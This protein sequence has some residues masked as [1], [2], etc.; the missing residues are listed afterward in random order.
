MTEGRKKGRNQ[1][2]KFECM[3]YELESSC[4]AIKEG[5]KGGRKGY[6]TERSSC[7]GNGEGG[8]GGGDQTDRNGAR[9][10]ESGGDKKNGGGGFKGRV[11]KE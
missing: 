9:G 7:K 5:G 2:G 6:I 1:P 10:G 4:R 11:L 8:G 3:Q